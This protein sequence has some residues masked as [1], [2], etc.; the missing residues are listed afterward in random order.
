MTMTVTEFLTRVGFKPYASVVNSWDAFNNAG[1]VLMQLWQENGQRVHDHAV[2]GAYL[3]VHC[4]D[5]AH[6]AQDGKNKVVGY[7]DRQKAITFLKS[8]GK[9]YA[10]LSSPPEGKHGAGMWA[11]YADLSNVYPV[12][13]V[14]RPTDCAEV[15]VILDRPI[16]T[17]NIVSSKLNSH[18]RD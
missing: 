12:L 6:Y 3:R 18:E 7:A 1:M 14:E 4:F 9:G 16:S 5:A 8:Q 2:A 11:K 10:A 15:F 17:D 13:A